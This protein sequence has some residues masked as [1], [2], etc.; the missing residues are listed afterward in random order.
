M[1]IKLSH[2]WRKGFVLQFGVG[3][4]PHG[5][6]H[7]KISQD[8]LGSTENGIE[9]VCSVEHLDELTHAGLGNSATTPDLHGLIGDLMG[10]AGCAHLEQTNGAG[11]VLRLLAVRHVAHLVCDGFE[12]GLVGFDES[13]HLGKSGGSLVVKVAEDNLD[14]LVLL[15]K[16]VL[17][18]DLDIVEGHVSCASGGRVGGLDLLGL[19]T[20]TTLDKEDTQA[21]VC[22]RTGDKVITPDTVGDPLLGSV[23]D[24]AIV[25]LAVGGLLGS[26]AQSSDIRTSE[27]LG[28]GETDLLLAAEDLVGNL[29]LPGLVAG[30][31]EDSFVEVVELL[32]LDRASHEVDSVEVLSRSK[33]HVQDTQLAHAINHLLAN[34]ATCR[35]AFLR[36]L[37]QLAVDKLPELAP[38]LPGL[39]VGDLAEVTGLWSDDLGL[40]ALDGANGEVLVLCEDLVSVKVVEGGCGILTGDLTQDSLTTGM[41]IDEVCEVVDCAVDDAPEGFVRGVGADLFAG[42][43]VC[44]FEML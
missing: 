34:V 15:A 25:M 2:N 4:V 9:L 1:K 35:L 10:S 18:R 33:A 8:L 21:L 17:G 27:G 40:L 44:H 13:D 11:K 31:V 3:E 43:C 26:R 28:N 12:P 30:E 6:S 14:T 29:I 7:T 23:D 36:L 24:L 38:Q 42:E 22:A 37:V 19:D 20:L 32:A 41:G 16:H 39:G 5:L